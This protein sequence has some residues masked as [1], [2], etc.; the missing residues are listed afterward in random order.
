MKKRPD[1]TILDT[2][3]TGLDPTIHEVVEFAA[4][5]RTAKGR[6]KDSLHIQIRAL[7]VEEPP[8]WA[9][10]LPGFQ[11]RPSWEKSIDYA[12]K[13][14]GL[15]RE[16]L[17]SSDR[18]NPDEAIR[19]IAEFLKGTMIIG[20][21][22]SFDMKMLGSM[23]DRAG[24]KGD[25]RLP[26]HLVDTVA[27]AYEHLTPYGL[28]SLS[29]SWTGGVCDFLDIPVKDAHTAMGDVLMTMKVYDRLARMS[30]LDRVKLQIKNE[31]KVKNA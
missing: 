3:T 31:K 28:K 13:V 24:L 21:N 2:E 19:R 29:L 9:E 18:M 26:Y 7:Y 14:N 10:H 23:V 25:I 5:K 17:T 12:L 8:P 11:G 27:L 6:V 15:T 20:H 30:W 1:E 22:P 16:E 4:V